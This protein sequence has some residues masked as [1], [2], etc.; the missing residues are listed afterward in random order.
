MNEDIRAS[1]VNL[2]NWTNGQPIHG[3]L[4]HREI[5]TDENGVQRETWID[6]KEI[7][8]TFGTDGITLDQVT[9]GVPPEQQVQVN[10]EAF[11]KVIE[12]IQKHENPPEK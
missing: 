2:T 9:S 10:Q 6:F 3:M 5:T 12:G 8:I 1:L 11:K 7:E 4:Q